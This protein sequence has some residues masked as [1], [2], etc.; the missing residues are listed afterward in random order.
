MQ[1]ET[2]Y[3][4]TPQDY[5]DIARLM[6]VL[7]PTITFSEEK[8]Q[9][10]VND[11]NAH[12]FVLRDNGRIIGCCTMAVFFSPTGKKASLEDVALLPEYQGQHLGR[13]LVEHALNEMRKEAPIHIQLTSRPSRVA[14]NGLYKALGFHQKETNVYFLNVNDNDDDDK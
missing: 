10:V 4:F 2:I 6:E 12:L 5:S 9:M 1:I 14:A 7:D 8:L 11:S 3:S 13:M